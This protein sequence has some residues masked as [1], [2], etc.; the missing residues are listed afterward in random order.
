MRFQ[1]SEGSHEPELR[2]E[3]VEGPS[4]FPSA[5]AFVEPPDAP[6]SLGEVIV[7]LPVAEAQA[8]AAGRPLA[9]AVA[10]LVVHGLLH[11]LAYD[12]EEAADATPMQ[13]REDDLL[14]ALGYAGA[15]SH[16]H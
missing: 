10:H 15:Y 5:F 7:C 14:S 9:G 6:P 4:G 8:A 11:L 1:P 13:A 16:G 12:H 2:P 3:P